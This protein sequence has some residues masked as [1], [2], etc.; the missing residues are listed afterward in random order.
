M[1]ERDFY[2]FAGITGAGKSTLF[3]TVPEDIK[4]TFRINTDEVVKKFGNWRNEIDQI[5]AAKIAVKLRKGYIEKGV[6]FNEET[7]LTGKTILNLIDRLRDK[8]YKLHLFYVGVDSVEIA[9]ERIR[10]RVL[11][12]GHD[13]PDEVVEKRYTESLQNLSKVLNKFDNV[14]IYDNTKKYRMILK[15]VN[16]K[17][18]KKSQNLPKWAE[19]IIKNN[20]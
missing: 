19:N 17:I 13:I 20:Y 5:K 4:N 1:S 10:S 12:G 11:K 9:K 15:I 6:S 7:T 14:V 8:N 2:L 16:K 18:I 3:S